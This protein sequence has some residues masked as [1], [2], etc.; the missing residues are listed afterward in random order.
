MMSD[1]TPRDR[2]EVALSHREPDRVPRDLGGS[3]ATLSPDVAVELNAHLGVEEKVSVQDLRT[4]SVRVAEPILK[5]FGI[6]TR[7]VYMKASASQAERV[8]TE[9]DGVYVTDDWGMDFV[10]HPGESHPEYRRFPLA[11]APDRRSIEKHAWPDPHDPARK[12]GLREEVQQFHRQGYAVGISFGGVWERSWYVRGLDNMMAD[13]ITDAPFARSLLWKITEIETLMYD[14]ILRDIGEYLSIVCF[15]SDMGTQSSLLVSPDLWRRYIRPCEQ[16]HINIFKK[17]TNAKIAHHACGAVRAL[18][19]D[20]IDMG[21]EVL[22]PVQTTA[23]G[24]DPFELK[25]E[26]GK[27]ICF[28]GGIDTQNVL[29]F[30][31]MQD[32]RDEVA[33]VVGALAPGGGYLSATCQNIQDDVPVQNIVAMYQALGTMDSYP[34][35]KTLTSDRSSR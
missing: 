31:T 25:R 18:I 24:M 3:H 9:E 20:Y 4:R 35:Q 21:I 12:K 13:L 8:H 11:D 22:N 19:P 23:A 30:G 32:V 14:F 27:D 7:W 26:F 33:R 10:L 6:D 5:R 16:E 17:W 34:I 15:S 29:P 1:L 28:W 2:V